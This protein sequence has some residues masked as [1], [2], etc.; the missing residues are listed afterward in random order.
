MDGL[1]AF[2]EVGKSFDIPA[3]LF[4]LADKTKTE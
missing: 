3:I 2:F 1:P 4:Y